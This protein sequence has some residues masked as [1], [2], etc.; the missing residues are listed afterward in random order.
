V[1]YILPQPV[2][3][4]QPGIISSTTHWYPHYQPHVHRP[5]VGIDLHIRSG[6]G[7]H[8]RHWR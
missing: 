3:V 7:N 4:A 1:V 2:V 5:R 8:K 6:G